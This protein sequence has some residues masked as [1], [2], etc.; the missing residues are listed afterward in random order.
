L[1]TKPGLG[2]EINEDALK[3]TATYREE[4]GGEHFYEIDG[5]VADW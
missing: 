1:P 5:S 3:Q 4:L 2:F